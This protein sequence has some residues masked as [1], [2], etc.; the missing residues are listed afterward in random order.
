MSNYVILFNWTGQGIKNVK[1]T[2]KRS[3]SFETAL[4]KISVSRLA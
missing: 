2:I 1:D 4:E 3:K